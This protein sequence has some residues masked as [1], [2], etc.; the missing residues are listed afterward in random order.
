MTALAVVLVV[1]AAV[2]VFAIAA[3]VVGRE[4][5]RLDSVAPRAVYDLEEAVTFVAD[6]LPPDA[7]AR[8]T[9]DEVRTLL[10]MHMAQLREKGLQPSVAVDHVQD[11]SDPVVVE[12]TSAAGYLIGQAE[13]AGLEVEDVDVVNIV[14]A[15][16]AYFERIGAVGPEAV[17]P[18]VPR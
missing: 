10:G 3:A 1:L 17:D 18:D 11:I 8:L 5:H 4:A 9:L 12:E 6:A 2:V 16:L 15:H 13:A 7:Q 14:D